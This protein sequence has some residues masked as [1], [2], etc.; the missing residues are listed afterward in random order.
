MNNKKQFI[1]GCLLYIATSLKETCIWKS[2]Y[3]SREILTFKV[4]K[5]CNRYH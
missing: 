2:K 5:H 4:E 1:V 3:P